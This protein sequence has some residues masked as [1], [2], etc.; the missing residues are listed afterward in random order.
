MG[1]RSVA[2]FLRGLSV[3]AALIFLAGCSEVPIIGQ[4]DFGERKLD[5]YGSQ[6]AGQEFF[7]TDRNLTR[8]DIFL[9]PSRS[10][11]DK[12]LLKERRRALKLLTGKNV[13]V[14]VYSWPDKELLVSLKQP[15]KKI[16]SSGMYKF[17]FEPL[18]TSKQQK[19]F[20]EVRA[21]Q[22]TRGQAIS[23]SMTNIDRYGEGRAF[24]NGRAVEGSDL[25][26][27]P[28][29]WMNGRMLLNSGVS[30]LSADIGFFVFWMGAILIVSVLTVL[31]WWRARSEAI[32]RRK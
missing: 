17:A 14:R 15:A 23:V 24:R 12:S 26:F 28:F 4:R 7:S 27:L 30:R 8:I 22:L 29:I 2:G 6:V 9:N 31:T 1:V 10:L 32:G 16:R 18:P 25:R 13:I 19:Y 11:K 20:L 21:P 3:A 5:V